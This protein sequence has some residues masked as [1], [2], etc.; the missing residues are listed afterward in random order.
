MATAQEST[1]S[2]ARVRTVIDLLHEQ[3]GARPDDV[4]YVFLRNGEEPA[5]TVTYRQLCDAVW[6]QATDLHTRGLS[7]R[8][9]LLMHPAGLEFVRT[10]LGCLRARV[11]AVPV[12]VPDRQEHLRKIRR[13][14]DD[15]GAS[16]L[17]TTMEVKTD[18]ERRFAATPELHGLTLVAI[19]AT[20]ASATAEPPVAPPVAHDIALVQYTSGSTGDPKGVMVRHANFHANAIQTERQRPLGP[21]GRMVSWL[22]HFHDMGLMFGIVLPLYAGA[23]SYLMAPGAFI[24]RPAR[25][26]E[27][28]ARVGAT[29]SVA[30][31]FAYELC[32]QA[33]ARGE[34]SGVGDL[35]RWRF[36]GNGAES[37]RHAT[38]EAFY[39]AFASHGFD[40]RAMC[41]GYGLAENTLTATATP[42]GR[43]PAV[44]W[45]SARALQAGR[46]ESV[47]PSAPGA[48]PVVSCGTP[49]PGTRVTIVDPVTRRPV[50]AGRVGEIW[51]DGPSVAAGY[52]GRPQDSEQIFRA[53]TEQT[54][55]APQAALTDRPCLRTGDLGYLQDGELYV[56]GRLKDVIVR[57]GRNYY[58][59]DIE[60]AAERAVP[61]LRP[62]CAAAFAAEDGRCERLIVVVEVDGRVLRNTGLDGVRD[63]IRRAI[64]DTHRL[65]VHEVVAVRRGALLKT[66]SGKIQ[67]QACKLA[68][69]RGH[70]SP[71]TSARADEVARPSPQET[72][73]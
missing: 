7:G 4:A 31:S 54:G 61:G 14:A 12:Q 33:A 43:A 22:P 11:L 24:R 27:A 17:L 35:S 16:V 68:Y 69:L 53:R 15:V 36:A 38:I 70:L 64:D 44:A 37:V 23:P 26:L 47:A 56:T 46:V 45:L 39:A 62:N 63:R 42:E 60:L 21:D 71:L 41:P 65:P 5:E 6:A 29:H 50:D 1:T 2:T 57:Q 20:A 8:R 59:Q 18:V 72:Q 9:A 30:P 28:I 73:K 67:R 58:P 34:M 52:W 66:S 40:Q 51:L 13:I 3:V 32:A 48:R 19:D 55:A 25:W 10:L 49:V